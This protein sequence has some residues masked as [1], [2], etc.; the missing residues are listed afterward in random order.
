MY[1]A[2]NE[3]RE[4][5]TYDIIQSLK[6]IVPLSVTM[7]EEIDALKIWA[8]DRARNASNSGKLKKYLIPKIEKTEEEDL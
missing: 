7:K 3:S 5:D 4:F 2:F 6:E 8:N 1:E